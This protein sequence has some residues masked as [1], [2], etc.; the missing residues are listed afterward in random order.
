MR[1]YSNGDQLWVSHREPDGE[2]NHRAN[3]EPG[4]S[5]TPHA[6]SLAQIRQQSRWR[7]I[8]DQMSKSKP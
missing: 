4:V 7:S 6:T 5:P 1:G 3:N 8:G 2:K